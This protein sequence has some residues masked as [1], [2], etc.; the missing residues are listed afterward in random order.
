MKARPL[1]AYLLP[2][3]GDMLWIGA[4]LGAIGLGPRMMNVDGDL[5]RHLTI[6]EYILTQ[7]QVPTQ[8]VFSY[9][10]YGANVTPHEWLAQVIFALAH[11]WLGLDG[12]VWISAAVI[13]LALWLVYRRAQRESQKV[14]LPVLLTVV[15]MAASSLH[16][17]TRPHIFTFLLLALWM[18]CLDN[19]RRGQLRSWWQMPV[20]MLLWANLHGAFIAGF[21]TWALYG[22]GLAWDAVLSP[23]EERPRLP[24]GFWRVFLL[25][26]AVSAL[27]TLINPSGIGLWGTSFGYIG[28]RY[29]V[30]HT[31]EYLPPDFHDPSTWPFL[32]LS[33][34]TVVS[35]GLQNRRGSAVEV[36]L[37]A[38]WLVMGLYSVRN[39]PLFVIVA[40]PWL[41]GLLSRW[42]EDA[43]TRLAALKAWLNLE[44]RLAAVETRLVGGLW[45]VG[46]ALLVMLAFSAGIALDFE[47]TGNCYNAK[48]FPVQAVDWMKSNSQEGEVLNYFPWGGYLLYQMWPEQ[49][50]FIDGQTDFYGESLTRQYEQVLTAAP[51]WEHVLDQYSVDYVLMPPEE[52]ISQALWQRADWQV[53][54][55]DETAVLFGL[56][57]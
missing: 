39:V 37:T 44:Q 55:Q 10:M 19:L 41:A 36:F 11:R 6:G 26:G 25:A 17:L 47:Q 35:F 56:K 48:I 32:L 3:L 42:L 52:A 18:N 15:A 51:D 16:W 14:L 43:G 5:G 40:V 50:V 38:A 28:N 2:S 1:T 23:S 29:L 53:L 20:L 13:G 46:S 21:V 49:Q 33:G 45:P 4:F 22:F 54:Y 7:A 9:S 31:A 27:V 30:S 8:D 34:L 12:V 57:K 24:G